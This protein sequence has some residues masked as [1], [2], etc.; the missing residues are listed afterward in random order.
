[1]EPSEDGSGKVAHIW[2]DWK[3]FDENRWRLAP[4]YEVHIVRVPNYLFV[5]RLKLQDDCHWYVFLAG[6][7]LAPS[8]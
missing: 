7:E 2:Y 4:R 3:Y 8:F 1:M 6:S 5:R